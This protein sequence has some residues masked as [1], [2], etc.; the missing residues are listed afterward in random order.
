MKKKI[1]LFLLVVMLLITVCYQVSAQNVGDVVNK[2]LYTDIVA[3]INHNPINSFNVDE[4]TAIVVED[5]VDYGFNVV[6]DGN[7][8]TLKVTSN[9]SVKAITPRST[10]YRTP[11]SLIDQIAADVLYT[12]IKT[13]VNGKEVK[14]YNIN[15][16]TIIYF[17]DL[18]PFGKVAW[19]ESTRSAKMWIERLPIAEYNPPQVMDSNVAAMFIGYW[20]NDLADQRD[21]DISDN[22]YSV[23]N[24]SEIGKDYPRY[25]YTIISAM[26]DNP[27][28]VDSIGNGYYLKIKIFNDAHSWNDLLYIPL[29][30]VNKLYIRQMILNADKTSESLSE[31]CSSFF[32]IQRH[33]DPAPK[34]PVV[35]SK[36]AEDTTVEKPAEDI[37][38]GDTVTVYGYV[39]EFVGTVQEINGDNVLVYW[40][41]LIDISYGQ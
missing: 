8:K 41:D 29:N 28:Y 32:S 15:G 6:W 3:Y 38:V 5:L 11:N 2:A 13:Y 9:D 24:R 25:N 23:R 31:K 39:N 17:K 40:Y 12:D 19:D 22:I 37:A 33:Y 10:V 26:K 34:K 20:T 1:S 4:Y 36:P 21:V 35:E 30:D 18:T 14:S 16:R 7:A 27:L